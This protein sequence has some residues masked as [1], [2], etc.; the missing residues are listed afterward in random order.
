MTIRDGVDDPLLARDATYYRA[1]D[2]LRARIRASLRDSA[3]EARAPAL[4]RAFGLGVSFAAVAALSWTLALLHARPSPD[5]DL[6]RDLVAAHVRSLM[7][8][9]LED[10][11]SSDRHTVKPWFTGK[12]DFAPPVHDLAQSGFPLT[13]GRLD[14]VHG[15]PVAALT[16]RYRLHV[17]NVFVWPVTAPNAPPRVQHRQGYSVVCWTRQAMELC[18]VSDA[19]APALEAL[20]EG[21]EKAQGG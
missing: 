21:L 13:G 6:A 12:L 2:E 1:P 7:P 19:E 3:R 15:R 20:A 18:A 14:Y 9:H 16:Y 5:E 17:V 11:A 8:G 4:W 10:V